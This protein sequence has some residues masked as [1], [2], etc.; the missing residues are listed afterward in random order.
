[1]VLAFSLNPTLYLETIHSDSNKIKKIKPFKGYDINILFK[2]VYRLKSYSWA[3]KS[4][5]NRA[6]VKRKCPNEVERFSLRFCRRSVY[7]LYP[8]Y[9][10]SRNC[11]LLLT[12]TLYLFTCMFKFINISYV[13]S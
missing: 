2:D 10:N 12:R 4:Y 9:N 5:A 3:C 6:I 11:N 1:M 13:N 7:L 8:N